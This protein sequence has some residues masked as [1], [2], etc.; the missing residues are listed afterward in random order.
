LLRDRRQD[1]DPPAPPP[2]PTAQPGQ[3]GLPGTRLEWEWEEDARPSALGRSDDRLGV[4]VSDGRFLWLDAATG[5]ALM[6]GFLWP[7]DIRGET[8]GSVMVDGDT[9][10]VVALETFQPQ[11]GDFPQTRSRVVAFDAEGKELW[12]LPELGDK[13]LYSATL[14][15][16]MALIG[17]HRGFE[18]NSLAAYQLSTGEIEWRYLADNYGFEKLITDGEHVYTTLVDAEGGG[19]AAYHL[20]SGA[21]IWAEHDPAVHLSDDVVL[22]DGRLYILTQPGAVALNPANGEINWTVEVGLAPEAGMVA[23][24]PYLYVVPAP[25]AGLSNRPGVL[26][27][28][29]DDGS[30]AWHALAGLV[31]DPLAANGDALWAVVRDLDEGT[32]SLSVLE[33]ANGLERA[34]IPLGT[35]V[36]EHYRLVA[37]GDTVYVLGDT[38]RAYRIPRE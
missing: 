23:R 6:G 34:R 36:E 2:P 32:V 12:N 1:Q 9:A 18:D 26:S 29:T 14:G 5:K 4:I 33:A 31:A 17:T 19:I 15:Q 16:G 30:V 22:D 38:L 25:T 13:H 28:S 35:D 8:W 3:L 27:I 10:L 7:D 21:L 37:N 11:L 20:D 24:A